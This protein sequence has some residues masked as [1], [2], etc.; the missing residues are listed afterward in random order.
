MN[1][2][3]NNILHSSE[4]KEFFLSESENIVRVNVAETRDKIKLLVDR[5]SVSN[6]RV[7]DDRVLWDLY[8]PDE[9]KTLQAVF[10]SLSPKTT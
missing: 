4:N 2:S 10:E 5:V 3:E 9:L 8:V 1:E 7:E 6:F